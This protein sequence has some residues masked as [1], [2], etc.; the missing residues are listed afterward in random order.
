MDYVYV[1]N[2]FEAALWT[3]MA[4]VCLCSWLRIKRTSRASSDARDES[5][6][7]MNSTD[8]EASLRRNDPS[9]PATFTS[10]SGPESL[11]WMSLVFLLF[12]CSEVIEM[13]TGARWKPLWLMFWKGGCIV[14]LIFIGTSYVRTLRSSNRT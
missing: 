7:L 3:L 5:I 12:A 9:Q 6:L 1:F 11:L 2:A 13:Q 14:S 10:S 8:N 4:I